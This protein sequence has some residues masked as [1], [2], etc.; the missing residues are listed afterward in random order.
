MGDTHNDM[1]ATRA[2]GQPWQNS[3]RVA[4]RPLEQAITVCPGLSDTRSRQS[5]CPLS[6]GWVGNIQCSFMHQVFAALLKMQAALSS[7]AAGHMGG[8]GGGENDVWNGNAHAAV[9]QSKETAGNR[10]LV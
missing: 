8:R 4:P 2:A 5:P 3:H 6:H 9:H 7:E 1:R 10:C